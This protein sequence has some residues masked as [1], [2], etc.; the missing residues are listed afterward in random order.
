MNKYYVR[1]GEET[2]LLMACNPIQAAVLAARK[3]VSKDRDDGVYRD[4]YDETPV[5]TLSTMI[6]VSERGFDAHDDDEDFFADEIVKLVYLSSDRMVKEQLENPTLTCE[7]A[8][9]FEVENENDS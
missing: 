3:I 4:S 8:G 9:L 7:E 6:S 1:W 5:V 2:V